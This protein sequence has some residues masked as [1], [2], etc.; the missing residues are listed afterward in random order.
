M[1]WKNLRLPVATMNLLKRYRANLERQALE[2]PERY[3]VN[4]TVD[5]LSLGSALHYLLD[6]QRAHVERAKKHRRLKALQKRIQDSNLKVYVPEEEET[7]P[8]P[9]Q[10]QTGVSPSEEPG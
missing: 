5:Q 10:G 1:R 8:R 4:L 3:P 7:K 6:Q 9:P 2:H